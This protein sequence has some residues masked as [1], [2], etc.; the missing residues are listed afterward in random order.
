MEENNQNNEQKVCPKCGKA[1]NNDDIFC[2]K[3]GKNLQETALEKDTNITV[4]KEEGQN[5]VPST[6][7]VVDDII[8]GVKSLI[9]IGLFVFLP[10]LLL[11]IIFLN[12][13]TDN[14]FAYSAEYY[15]YHEAIHKHIA[16]AFNTLY[17]RLSIMVLFIG[18][19]FSIT[20]FFI[21]FLVNRADKI[22]DKLAE[23]KPDIKRFLGILIFAVII[24]ILVLLDALFR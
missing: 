1:C 9:L 7:T 15:T 22:L 19:F 23:T 11:G 17:E 8:R 2:S 14:L 3:C 24:L 13:T 4:N 10:A 21:I 20:N 12:G 18:I 5:N 16:E 6:N